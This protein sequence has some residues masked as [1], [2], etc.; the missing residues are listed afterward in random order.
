ME[1]NKKKEEKNATEEKKK[2]HLPDAQLMSPLELTGDGDPETVA[3]IRKYG[4]R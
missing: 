1:E 2:K 3:R 4:F